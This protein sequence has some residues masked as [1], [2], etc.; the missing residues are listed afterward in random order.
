MR[1]Y[2]LALAV[3]VL[4]AACPPRGGDE[5]KSGPPQ[6]TTTTLNPQAVP[7]SSTRMMP[8]AEK[9]AASPANRIDAAPQAVAVDL[10]EYSINMPDTLASGHQTLQV[11]NHGKETHGMIIDGD[12]F[13]QAIVAQLPRGDTVAV[14]V[15]LAPG[16][17]RVFCPVDGHRGKGMQR[18][19]TV[20]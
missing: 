6:T 12:G 10:L 11:T 20:R 4:C 7:E 17:Y 13:H 5:S 8:V 19:L 2:A 18:S 15:D 16:T 3:L 1:R 14:E 9:P